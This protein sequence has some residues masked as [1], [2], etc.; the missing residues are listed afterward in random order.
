[1]CIYIYC[2]V[3]Q[4]LPPKCSFFVFRVNRPKWPSDGLY[5]PYIGPGVRKQ[6]LGKMLEWWLMGEHLQKQNVFLKHAYRQC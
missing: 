5:W 3:Y 2:I 4:Q 1:M 6:D